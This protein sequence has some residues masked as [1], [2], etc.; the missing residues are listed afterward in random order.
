MKITYKDG[1]IIVMTKDK[2]DPGDGLGEADY[3][4]CF[5]FKYDMDYELFFFIAAN[6]GKA[7]QNYHFINSIR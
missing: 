2:A 7:I 5:S 1:E 3:Q 6:S 4:S